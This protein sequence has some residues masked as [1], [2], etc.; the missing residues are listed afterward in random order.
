LLIHDENRV[1]RSARASKAR[2]MPKQFK[3]TRLKFQ[4][5][6]RAQAIRI[7]NLN[8]NKKSIRRSSGFNLKFQEFNFKFKIS[9]LFVSQRV[10]RVEARRLDCRI[11]PE[12]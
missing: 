2:A 7:G 3:I 12:K 4:I 8:L 9:G 11:D 6:G 5:A 1:P 10:H